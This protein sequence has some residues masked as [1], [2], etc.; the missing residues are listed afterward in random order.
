MSKEITF[1]LSDEEHKLRAAEL[2]KMVRDTAL[3]LKMC[4]EY[5]NKYHLYFDFKNETFYGDPADQ[6]RFETEQGWYNSSMGC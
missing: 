1:P 5:A 2:A 4:E 6:E 3:S